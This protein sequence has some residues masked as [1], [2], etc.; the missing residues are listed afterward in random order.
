[1]ASRTV[2][3]NASVFNSRN[4]EANWPEKCLIN[5]KFLIKTHYLS[6]TLSRERPRN[7]L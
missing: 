2:N 3:L 1:M 5:F 6:D 7:F 4:L